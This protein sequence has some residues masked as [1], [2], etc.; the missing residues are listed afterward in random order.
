[1]PP[2]KSYSRN[3]GMRAIHSE[4][5]NA[6]LG[7]W[8]GTQEEVVVGGGGGLVVVMTIIYWGH[9]WSV[10]N[11]RIMGQCLLEDSR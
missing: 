8:P 10:W 6:T 4:W 2:D 11:I 5:N 1:M 9:V 3:D 7:L